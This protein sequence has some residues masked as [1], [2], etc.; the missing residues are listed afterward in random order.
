MEDVGVEEGVQFPH[1]VLRWVGSGTRHPYP[2]LCSPGWLP[3]ELTGR[4]VVLLKSLHAENNKA[5]CCR[6]TPYI[7]QT[8]TITQSGIRVL[9]IYICIN[10]VI[11]I[12]CCR[13]NST[14]VSYSHLNVR[15]FGSLK[16]NKHNNPSLHSVHSTVNQSKYSLQELLHVNSMLSFDRQCNKIHST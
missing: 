16:T 5:Q 9:L 15:T 12:I 6:Y 2:I 8:N 7:C 10:M 14:V 3:L 11:T 1:M 13:I 4:S